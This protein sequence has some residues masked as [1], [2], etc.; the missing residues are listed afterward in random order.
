MTPGFFGGFCVFRFWTAVSSFS[1][2]LPARDADR[3]IRR[4]CFFFAWVVLP[5]K[6]VSVFSRCNAD[7]LFLRKE[8]PEESAPCCNRS[9]CR[10]ILLFR[11]NLTLCDF[12]TTSDC[13]KTGKTTERIGQQ[14]VYSQLNFEEKNDIINA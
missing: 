14:N 3:S 4:A 10:G 8:K 7:L 11:L 12:G 6:S 9:E 2:V 13:A 1:L 5:D